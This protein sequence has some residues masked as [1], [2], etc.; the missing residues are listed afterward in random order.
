MTDKEIAIQQLNEHHFS[1]CVVNKASIIFSSEKS[2]I[3][4]LYE[5]HQSKQVFTSA[6][7][8]DKVVGLGAAMLWKALDIAQ[9]HAHIVSQPALDYLTKHDIDISYDILTNGI[10]SRTGEGSCP[11]ETIAL[12]SNSLDSFLRGVTTFLEDKELI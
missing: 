9:L 10:K 3:L 5:A 1:L 12:K 4:P 6:G 11:I 7:A 2:G 8:A